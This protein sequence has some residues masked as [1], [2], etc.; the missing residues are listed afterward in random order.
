MA[1]VSQWM[2]SG[3]AVVLFLA[4][5]VYADEAPVHHDLRLTLIPAAHTLEVVDTLRVP[6][7][8]PA[9]FEFT[10]HDGL[11]PQVTT[12]GV[13]L[14]RVFSSASAGN[15]GMNQSSGGERVP[16][17]RYRVSLPAGIRQ[18]TLRYGGRIHHPLAAQGEEYGRSFRETPGS[19]GP[20]GVFLAASTAWFPR[21]D[22]APLVTFNLDITVPQG[23]DALSQGKRARHETTAGSQ[24]V[25]WESPEAQDDIYVSAARFTAYQRSAGR[26]SAMAYLRTP[27]DTLADKY[28]D[29]TV[30]YLDMYNKLLGPYPY[31]KFA[32]VENYWETGYGM[33]SFTLLGPRIIRF[34]FIIVSSYPHEIL[35]N[36]W[37]NGVFV[38]YQ[39]GNWAEGLTA[40]LADHLFKEQRGQ[41]AQYRRATLQNYA[42]FVAESQDFPLTEFR[43][44][45]SS[46]TQAVGYGKTLMFFHMLRRKLGDKAFVA[47]LRKLY[48]DRLFKVT[49]FREVEQAFTAVSGQELSDFFAQWIRRPGAPQLTVSQARAERD[50]DGYLLT[51]RLAQTQTG[52]AYQLQVPLAVSLKGQANAYQTVVR[53]SAKQKTLKLHLP[54][55]P[56]LLDVD[57]E[58]DLFRRVSREEIPPALSLAFGARKSLIVLPGDEPPALQAAWQDFA[59][60]WA[61]RGDVEIK[62][63]DEIETLPGDRAIWLLG[64]HNRF[65][66]QLKQALANNYSAALKSSGI[67][68]TPGAGKPSAAVAVTRHPAHPDLA[69]AWVASADA[70]AVP[71]LARKLPHYSKYSY[72]G[73]EGDEPVNTVKGQWPV[74]DSPLSIAVTQTDGARV[75]PRRAA[76]TPRHA[77]AALPPAFS[78]QRLM[79]DARWL[80]DPARKGRG[81]GTPELDDVADFIAGQFQK[82][83]LQGG[84]DGGGHLQ[85]WTENVGDPPRTITLKNVIGVL[86]GSNPDYAGQSVL[87]SAHYDHLGTGWPD[88]HAGDEGQIHPGADDNASGV[89][90]LLELARTL[91]P[92]WR[93]QRTVVFAAFS[94]EEARLLGSR[95]Y[96]R[97]KAVSPATVIAALNLDTVGRLGKRPVTVFGTGSAREWAHI[98]RGV[99]FVT[100]IPVK[101]VRDDA[102]GSDQLSF[103]EAGVPA[104]QFFSG[105]H[106]D[107]HRPGDT[108]DKL[109]GAGMATVASVVKET[110]DYLA[111]RPEALASA[112]AENTTSALQRPRA[113]GRR[114]SLGTVPDFSFEGK[115]VKL[116]GVQAGS[117][118]EA[119]GLQ[120]GDVIIGANGKPIGS[121]RDFAALLRGLQPGDDISLNYIRG[122]KTLS[123]TAKAKAR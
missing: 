102:G 108:A 26:I 35:H 97:A 7:R 62:R 3:L 33:P 8:W 11:K 84:G 119:A 109:D 70:A 15:A 20:D 74:V 56:L 77:L 48:R 42:D 43:A 68:L 107:Y 54:A 57:P 95:H 2:F 13:S 31:S 6:Q 81:L 21:F 86:P 73:F 60:Q 59:R 103:I 121:L 66:P 4:P 91:G 80:A 1:R 14:S 117:P 100:G 34:P 122:K 78:E 118:A 111:T 10:L 72:L 39:S 67:S 22:E 120:T 45:H 88:V 58:F 17:A 96:V 113:S 82:A 24:R 69:L 12:H 5:G 65:L 41:G 47:G 83:G 101:G 105:V 29:A 25:R 98:F 79:D 32:L 123:S 51:A 40:Y 106:G 110:L 9:T 89:A 30:R 90:V 104:V 92:A 63:D 37:G 49:G 114:V 87:I 23:W 61:R 46:V 116:S 85:I 71:G 28:L 64:W 44:R 38:D 93:P 99:G 76:L 75:K 50:G 115:G 19:I 55:R 18:F 27:D 112:L 16:W 52:P 94:G 36:W 53:L